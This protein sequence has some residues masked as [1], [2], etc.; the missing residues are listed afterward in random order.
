MLEKSSLKG[1]NETP[2]WSFTFTVLYSPPL[3]GL[4]T[5]QFTFKEEVLWGAAEGNGIQ[6]GEEEAQWRTY[7]PLQVPERRLW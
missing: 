5:L 4:L 1:I 6:F 3:P 7:C 2:D